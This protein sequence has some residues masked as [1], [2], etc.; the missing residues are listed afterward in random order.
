MKLA[1]FSGSAE[2]Y[3]TILSGWSDDHVR[4]GGCVVLMVAVVVC[5]HV[6]I[7]CAVLEE[8]RD[9]P[10]LLAATSVSMSPLDL[11]SVG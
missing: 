2:I 8:V 5:K 7:V 1:T 9:D 3:K 4:A 6:L 11:W 10:R